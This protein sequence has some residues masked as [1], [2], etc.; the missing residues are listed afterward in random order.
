MPRWSFNASIFAAVFPLSF[1]N[2]VVP[3][4]SDCVMI[5][6]PSGISSSCSSIFRRSR[7]PKGFFVVR[8]FTFQRKP[9]S[10][11][12]ALNALA[13]GKVDLFEVCSSAILVS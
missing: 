3:V 12:Y 7:P 5:E 8:I 2:H 6:T 1:E 10:L 4:L 11:R 13:L 9:R